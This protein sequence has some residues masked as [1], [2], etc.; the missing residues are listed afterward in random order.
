[1]GIYIGRRRLDAG[2]WRTEGAWVFTRNGDVWTQQGN[3]LVGTGAV[4]NA[5][6]GIAVAL[7]A[8]GNT[9]IV[10]GAAD[11]SDTGAAWVFTRSGDVW[12]Q[13]GKK[14]VGSGAGGRSRQGMSVALSADGNTAILGGPDTNHS[15]D[16][17]R[18]FGLGPAGA[19]WVFGRSSGVWMQQGDKLVS[20]NSRSARQGTFVALSADGNIAALAGIA[21]EGNVDPV[22]VFIR[23]AAHWTQDN[24]L[25]GIGAVVKSASSVALSADGR[26]MVIGAP[27]DNGGIGAAWVL[28]RKGTGSDAQAGYGEPLAKSGY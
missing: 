20:G 16:R 12:T 5:R 19:A 7:S 21:D 24:E 23:T 3:K 26:S 13:Q 15:S 17:S 14:L 11:N 18:P 6:Q 25:T 27:N 1:V 22:S 9:A 28:R 8:D 4:G 10:G 2:G